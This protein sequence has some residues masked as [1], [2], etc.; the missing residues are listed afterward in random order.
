MLH[1][2]F[3]GGIAHT[4]RVTGQ[5]QV[6]ELG[7]VT[8]AR[9][10]AAVDARKGLRKRSFWSSVQI[11]VINLPFLRFNERDDDMPAWACQNR[12]KPAARAKKGTS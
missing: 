7:R 8:G 1:G 5:F 11:T 10:P 4:D 3:D 2:H 9:L 6:V 12:G